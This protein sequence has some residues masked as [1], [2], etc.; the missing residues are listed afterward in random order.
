M[1]TLKNEQHWSAEPSAQARCVQFCSCLCKVCS[2]VSEALLLTLW[3]LSHS[4]VTND[5]SSDSKAFLRFI[6]FSAPLQQYTV[7]SSP[8]NFFMCTTVFH[9]GHTFLRCI[10]LIYGIPLW[11]YLSEA[12]VKD[13]HKCVSLMEKP[14]YHTA[15]SNSRDDTFTLTYVLWRGIWKHCTWR[16]W[17][18]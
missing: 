6:A 15:C 16:K 12:L 7:L 10:D 3:T 9:C 4:F 17:L 18:T 11:A 2:R 5:S 1:V 13:S 8:T 14:Q